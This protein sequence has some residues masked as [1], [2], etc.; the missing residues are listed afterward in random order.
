MCGTP[1]GVDEVNDGD[2][3]VATI[4]GLPKLELTVRR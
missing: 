3:I 2:K 1:S 4:E